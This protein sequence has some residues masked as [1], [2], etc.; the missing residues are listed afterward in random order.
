MKV[1]YLVLGAGISGLSFVENK[2]PEDYLVLEKNAN[3]GGYCGTTI[4]NDYVWDYAGH[5]F[6]FRDKGIR[7][8]FISKIGEENFV[9]VRKNTKI[10]YKGNLIN[11][12]FQ[13]N[14][15]EL[16]K[17]EFIDCL[18]DLYRKEEKESYTGFLDM[19][20]GKFG[21]SIVE[22]FLKPYNEKLYACN[23]NSLDVEAMGRFFP[24][25]DLGEI[26]VNMKDSSQNS[27]NDFF[28]Y[29]KSGAMEFIKAIDSD[30][31]RIV[32]NVRIFSIDTS[33]K[34]V[35][36]D[37]GDYEYS[38]LISSV[39]LNQLLDYAGMKEDL[40]WNKVLVF[41]VG[42]D[43]KTEYKGIH[44]VYVPDRQ[45]NFYR[46]GFYDNILNS[47]KGSVYVEVG[48][49]KEA[50]ID[51]EKEYADALEGM[52]QMGI[53][54]TQKVVDYQSVIMDPA[55]VHIKDA[56][57]INGIRQTLKEKDIY[58][59]GRYGEWTYCSIEDCIKAAIN[60]QEV[61]G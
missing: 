23:L 35:Y 46:I 8:K 26:I 18:Y 36:T 24:Y 11:Y 37:Q 27:Y 34:T 2:M 30:V 33:K 21:A 49:D 14:I 56:D 61:T 6:H 39:P 43:R 12:P 48:F 28:L 47:D 17:E 3:W 51:T 31:S 52:K 45:I 5:F 19:L 57:R 50:H 10:Y 40:S 53:I 20:Y 38:Y 1:K 55:Y 13:K 41:N 44:W 7:E 42:F 22:K 9:K 59:L 54:D 29:P 25:A 58:L 15:H 60:L 4:R 32:Y 16:P